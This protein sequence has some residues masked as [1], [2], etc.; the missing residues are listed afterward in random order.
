MPENRG[1]EAIIQRQEKKFAEIRA[2]VDRLE[3]EGLL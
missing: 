1:H 2:E 3:K